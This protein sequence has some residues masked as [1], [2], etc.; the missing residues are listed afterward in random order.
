V[1][2]DRRS[3]QSS[4]SGLSV[5]RISTVSISEGDGSPSFSSRY[6]EDFEPVHCLGKGGF[7]VVFEARNKI[8]DCLYAIK[9]IKLPDR[10]IYKNYF[11]S[12]ALTFS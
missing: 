5:G 2:T 10:Y 11:P 8:D 12:F 9:R 7:G 4:D 6:L 1:N 3:I